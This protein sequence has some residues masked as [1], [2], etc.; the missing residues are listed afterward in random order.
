MRR[1]GGAPDT[2]PEG[3]GIAAQ[4]DRIA[5]L[6]ATTEQLRERLESMAERLEPVD[7]GQTDPASAA[8]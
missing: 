6:E 3:G 4:P 2:R 1:G 5:D 7:A 8:G